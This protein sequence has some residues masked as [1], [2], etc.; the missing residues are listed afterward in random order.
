MKWILI[1]NKNS[2]LLEY[3]L[4]ENE[5]CEAIVKYNPVHRSARVSSGGKHTLYFIESAGS[6]S[7]K[8]IFKNQYGIEVGNMACDKWKATE[9]TVTIE[10]KKY[11]YKIHNNPVAEI[12]IYENETHRHLV[13]CGLISNENGIAISL[14]QQNNN[15]GNNYLLLGLCWYLFLP[16]AKENLVEYAA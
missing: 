11:G 7:G 9:G 14:S 13:S 8:Y 5:K 10:S 6:L 1:S 4:M 15:A 12:Q 2:L 16:M 3:H